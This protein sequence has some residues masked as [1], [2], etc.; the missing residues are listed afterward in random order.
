[1]RLQQLEEFKQVYIQLHDNPDADAIASGYALYKYYVSKNIC[2]K[3]FY[4]G[5]Y[6]ITKSN[7][8]FMIEELHIPI[9]Y[10]EHVEEI[11]VGVLITVDSQYGAG[12]ITAIKAANV[13]IIDHHQLEIDDH[14]IAYCEIQPN[15]GS[16]ST[17]VWSMLKKEN[18]PIEKD[19]NLGTALFYGLYMDTN[20]FAELS[21]PLDKDMHDELE[22]DSYLIKRLRNNNISLQELEIAGIAL[23]RYIF[24]EDYHYAIIQAKPCDPNLLGL[25]SDFLLQVDQ[26]DICVVYNVTEEGFKFSVRSCIR[27]IKANELAQ[28]LVEDIGQGGGHIEKAGGF[29]SKR[30]YDKKYAGIHS[31]NY[32]GQRINQYYESFDVINFSQEDLDT[33]EFEKYKTN[34]VTLGYVKLTDILPVKAR[35]TIRTLEGDTEIKVTDDKCLMVGLHGEVFLTDYN[36]F[37]EHFKIVEDE[38]VL[39]TEYYPRI[40]NRLTDEY[41]DLMQYVKSCQAK[42]EE[43]VMVKRLTKSLKLFTD[44]IEE[45]YLFGK[46]DDYLIVG[47]NDIRNVY[48]VK[49]DIFKKLYTRMT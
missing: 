11:K 10:I 36:K 4:T 9:E 46:K 18:Y 30:K 5:R 8:L 3:L 29:I 16:C 40:K 1:M 6:Q 44:Y 37:E 49:Q 32:F 2:T 14:M 12:N 17:V 31:E 19:K 45:S 23:I 27:E 15:I 24:N 21:N 35:T 38:F 43:Y 28:Y 22:Y 25:I 47:G 41:E 13:A 7:L 26:I 42:K 39:E 20:Q 33:T 34:I 48:I